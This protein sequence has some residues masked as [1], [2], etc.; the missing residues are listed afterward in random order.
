[1]SDRRCL[2]T[3]ATGGLGR[4]LVPRLLAAGWAVTATGRNREAGAALAAQGARFVPCDLAHDPLGP[5]L[6]GVDAVHH[7]AALSSPWGPP[8]AFD[9][10]NVVATR[11]LLAAAR[12]AGARR[13][14]HVSTP[15]IYADARDQF[16]ITED[17]PLPARFAN[18]Y[19][20]TKHAAERLA[21]ASA[22][23][24]FATVAIR[25]RAV[26]GP[27]DTVL[28]PRL[29]RAAGRGRLALP[30]G[31]AAL[32]EPT[33]ARDVCDALVA[34]ADRAERVSG[35]AF[36]VSGGQPRA[37]RELA[38]R[39]FDTLGRSARIVPVERRLALRLA[40]WAEAVAARLPGR[41]EPPLTRYAVMVAGW[42]QT[43]DL[44][45]AGERLGWSPQRSP[46]AALDWALS[47][48][49]RG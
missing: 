19:A 25:P 30:H 17:T 41:P 42:S 33:D 23:P 37:L 39:V 31:G 38:R 27:W 48:R 44:S 32:I 11:R 16:G 5:V 22:E 6:A 10:A 21:L 4:V 45:R 7:L 46:E 26:L 40:G 24:G 9:A 29:L 47:A 18:D 49:H 2:V 43:F 28:L 34:A 35:Q 3:G 14:V 1:M 8:A 20:R 13:F 12:E 15:S 36:N